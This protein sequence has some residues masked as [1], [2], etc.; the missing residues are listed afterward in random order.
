MALKTAL[1]GMLNALERGL[2]SR[3][4]SFCLSDERIDK[5]DTCCSWT[6]LKLFAASGLASF[7]FVDEHPDFPYSVFLGPGGANYNL[8]Q[9][10]WRDIGTSV[11]QVYAHTYADNIIYRRPIRPLGQVTCCA[12]AQEA[13]QFRG[14]SIA[15]DAGGYIVWGFSTLL[16]GYSTKVKGLKQGDKGVLPLNAFGHGYRTIWF[17]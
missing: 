7:P 3:A 13:Q 17:G 15:Y 4:I 14:L 10:Y 5:R 6:H 11:P 1:T 2:A 9:M 12:D 16:D 8:P